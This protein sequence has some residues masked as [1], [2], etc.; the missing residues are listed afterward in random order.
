MRKDLDEHYKT[1]KNSTAKK[2]KHINV[3]VNDLKNKIFNMD[4]PHRVEVI[5]RN[6]IRLLS[7]VAGLAALATFF[8]MIQEPVYIAAS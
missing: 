5:L 3:Q 6:R 8:V 1:V 4:I 2:I 7:I